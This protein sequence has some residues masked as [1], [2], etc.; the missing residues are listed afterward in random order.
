MKSVVHCLLSVVNRK[1]QPMG[2]V[3]TMYVNALQKQFL[4]KFSSFIFK[5]TFDIT[6]RLRLLR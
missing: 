5:I 4:L 6:F 1:F 3:I 2:G